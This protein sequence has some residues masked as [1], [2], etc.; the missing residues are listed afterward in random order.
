[1]DTASP[2]ELAQLIRAGRDGDRDAVNRLLELVYDDFRE[3]AGRGEA[4]VDPLRQVVQTTLQLLDGKLPRGA[5]SI[6]LASRA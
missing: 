6:P 2:D 3:I 1:M 5:T 4:D